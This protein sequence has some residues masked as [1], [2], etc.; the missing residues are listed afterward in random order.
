LIPPVK[1]LIPSWM[2]PSSKFSKGALLIIVPI[3]LA[4]MNYA[5]NPLGF[6][7]PDHDESIYLRRAMYLLTGHG[8]QEQSFIGYDHPY[9]GQIFLASV[10]R[11]LDYPNSLHPEIGD[12]HSIQ[13][14]FYVPR[15]VV[16]I[17]AVLDTIL[18]FKIAEKRYNIRVA[19]IASILFAVL[20]A[21]FLLRRVFLDTLLLPF[22][23]SSVLLALS[24]KG[25]KET[26]DGN[27]YRRQIIASL[28]SGIALG[29]AIF[30]KIPA[31]T[32]IPIVS[33]I[34]YTCNTK[35]LKLLAIWFVPVIFI[36]A[37]WLIY[38]MSV[39]QF[40]EWEKTVLYQATGK[41][42][43]GLLNALTVF[44]S[45][46][47]LLTILGII[48]MI[49]AIIKR[50][51]FLILWFF[52]PLVFF[53]LV[54]FVQGF[55]LI[56]I[57]PPLCIGF[58]RLIVHLSR[59]GKK[60]RVKSVSLIAV[61]LIIILFPLSSTIKNVQNID[62]R[63]FEAVAFLTKYLSNDKANGTNKM[64]TVMANPTFLWIPQYVFNL[65]DDYKTYYDNTPI[66]GDKILFVVDKSF[67][68][69]LSAENLAGER[70]RQLYNLKGNTQIASFGRGNSQ[71]GL[72]GIMEI[73]FSKET[74]N[75]QS[76]NLLD[77]HHP[78]SA[79]NNL[80]I[81]QKDNKMV[82]TV[83]NSVT[84]I[85]YYRTS[86]EDNL[87]IMPYSLL[88]LDYKT[89]VGSGD[90]TFYV[91]INSNNGTRL[92]SSRLDS[93]NNE[94]S[95]NIFVIPSEAINNKAKMSIHIVTETPG[96]YVITVDKALI[97]GSLKKDILTNTTLRRNIGH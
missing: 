7:S 44:Y 63:P 75:A 38:A 3:A 47:S 43:N 90:A 56:L 30:T 34:I 31:F 8:P 52:P 17:L 45:Y 60:M 97:Y 94:L 2:P 55:H 86:L 22:L 88:Y 40:E 11:I 76:I 10:L 78:W 35:W 1:N 96:R 32:A 18:I 19:F 46:N 93:T 53:Y 80:K 68:N 64:I 66:K 71:S 9:F 92:W 13:T 70:L 25:G 79:T 12:P 29:L 16:G 41:E 6:Y 69:I 4:G 67:L 91:Q 14:L 74:S 54:G 36:P 39:G 58:S 51:Y 21:P 5:W 57:I 50:D 87:N 77:S 59:L 85:S 73:D 24:V 23:L 84:R 65:K 61:T 26:T 89:S 81:L 95:H 33:Y 42:R 48:G 49:F 62:G 82:M 15:A 20:P 37:F 28:L 72:I 27:M 83:N